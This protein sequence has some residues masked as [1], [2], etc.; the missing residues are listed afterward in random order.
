MA[1]KTTQEALLRLLRAQP[2]AFV[3]GVTCSRELGVS[4]TAVW[5]QI[6]LLRCAGYNIEAV[7]ARGYRLLSCPDLL[8][9]A[10]IAAGLST[11][12]VG[13]TIRYFDSLDSTNVRAWQLGEEGA[14][15]GTV[16]VADSQSAGK[17]R[18]G[19]FWTSP[20]GVNL[21][22]SLLLRP[23]LPPR[24]APQLTF[25][26]AL[27]VARAVE[28]ASGL[29]PTVKWPNDILLDGAKVAGLLNEMNAE[30]ERINFLV[31]GIGVNLNMAAAQFPTQLRYPATSLLLAT[32]R[33]VSR[34]HFCRLLLEELDR[35]YRLYLEEGFTPIRAGW[36]G[37]FALVGKQVSVDCT[38]H[39]ID[40]TVTGIDQD[41]ALLL[42][43]PAGG[44]ERILAGDVRPLP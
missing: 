37:Y 10:E 24:D 11:R 20:P 30:T 14:P 33:A 16:V 7:T 21:Y 2:G 9:P 27:A 17:G 15:E 18:L 1:A 8:L 41:G 6:E 25:L 29:R 4:R 19:R 35:L 42:R 32:G 5:K 28:A 22:L 44:S 26:S 13:R 36:E 38:S 23:P 34:L 31:L 12:T 39:T 40:G 3:S 43:L